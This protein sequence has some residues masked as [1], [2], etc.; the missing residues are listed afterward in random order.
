MQACAGDIA[1]TRRDRGNEQ[2][3]DKNYHGQL[4]ERETPEA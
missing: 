2:A 1:E 3:D 4:Y